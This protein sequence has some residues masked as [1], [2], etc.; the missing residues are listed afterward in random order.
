M[1][2]DAVGQAWLVINDQ[3]NTILSRDVARRHN[4]ELF[5]IQVWAESDFADFSTW[6]RAADCRAEKHPGQSHIVD[7]LR[8]SGNLVSP[9]LA[10]N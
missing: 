3:G 10:R 4:H 8:A 1:V 9:F 5:P 2:H 6:Y 7:V